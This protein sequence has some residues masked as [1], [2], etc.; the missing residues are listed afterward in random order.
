VR[1]TV[2][3]FGAVALF[4]RLA[5]SHRSDKTLDESPEQG[6]P[7]TAREALCQRA[8]YTRSIRVKLYEYVRIIGSSQG[9]LRFC[10]NKKNSAL[11]VQ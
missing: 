11:R 6:L 1:A 9:V 8:I 10:Y 4:K 7:K 2:L 3:V 5:R